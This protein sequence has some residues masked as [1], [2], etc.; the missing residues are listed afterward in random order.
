MS[1]LHFSDLKIGDTLP[2]RENTITQETIDK[3]AL[4]HFDFNPLHTNIE[5]A[6]RARVLNTEK[7]VIHGMFTLSQMASVITGAWGD[8]GAKI[9]HLESKFTKPVPVD[10]TVR[11]E[12]SVWELHPREAGASWVVVSG[13]AIDG[14]GDTIAVATFHVSVPD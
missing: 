9:T 3:T 4:A 13:E 10:Q 5:W 6:K 12:A 11:Y 1:S 2:P 7:T 14:D 8:G